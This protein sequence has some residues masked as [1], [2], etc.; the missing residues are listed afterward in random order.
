MKSNVAQKSAALMGA[1]SSPKGKM[2]LGLI[3]F[4]YLQAVVTVLVNVY[5]ANQLG[6]QG[7]GILGY[8]L[9]VSQIITAVVNFGNEKTL[10]RDLTHAENPAES[11]TASIVLRSCWAVLAGI[12]VVV[13]LSMSSMESN[14]LWPIVP[15]AIAGALMGLTP[16]GW[17]DF[18]YKMNIQAG[19]LFAE[20]LFYALAVVLLLSIE[21]EAK[22]ALVAA[23]TFLISR[24]L[25]IAA[26]WLYVL[27]S[28]QP[29]KKNLR[30]NINWLF[31]QNILVYVAILAN[32]IAP[33]V[34]QLYLGHKSGLESL[35]KYF[36]AF[37]IYIMIQT[38]QQMFN[39]LMGPRI[40]EITKPGSE[41][42]FVR[43]RLFRFLSYSLMMNLSLLVPLIVGAGWG[44]RTF[45]KPEYAEAILPFRILCTSTL[46]YGLGLVINQFLI[47]LRL[48][49]HYFAMS[50]SRGIT[51]LLLGW[52]LIPAYGLIGVAITLLICR[53]VFLVV[54]FIL[55]WRGMKSIALSGVIVS[56]EEAVK[57]VDL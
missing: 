33:Y 10:V 42:A 27:R 30:K 5:L 50:I 12:G 16:R 34:N 4:N 17:F 28:F 41:V 7:Y 49:F 57:E 22:G 44:F 40:A 14:Q 51:A 36:V 23:S 6:E 21:L 39:R 20:K 25:S 26:Q 43:S 19:I 45:L 24:F 35:G 37:Q 55:L 54:Q 1:L 48:N 8:G 32:L 15:C 31:Q 38:L 18:Q 29:H 13:W 2:A 47:C 53:L 9:I 52:Y 11:M 46:L 3:T 56:R